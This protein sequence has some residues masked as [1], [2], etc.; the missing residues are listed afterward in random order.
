MPTTVRPA[1]PLVMVRPMTA[2]SVAASRSAKL[3]LMTQ[4]LSPSRMKRPAAKRS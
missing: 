4:A 2:V 3:R 1:E